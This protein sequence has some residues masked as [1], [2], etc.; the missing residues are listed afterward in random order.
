MNLA[1]LRWLIGALSRSS[2]MHCGFERKL[3][4]EKAT[5]CAARRRLPMV[6]VDDTTRLIGER[7]A[8]TLSDVFEG[9]PGTRMIW[10]AVAADFII[11]RVR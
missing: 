5:Q 3:T 4:H 11:R 2:W 7:G 10:A 9:R 1:Y 6:E 8:V